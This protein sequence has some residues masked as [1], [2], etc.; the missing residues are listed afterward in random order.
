MVSATFRVSDEGASMFHTAVPCLA[1]RPTFRMNLI[2]G[3][4]LLYGLKSIHKRSVENSQ[5][6]KCTSG[7]TEE[8]AISE[9]RLKVQMVGQTLVLQL[10]HTRSR[11]WCQPMGVSQ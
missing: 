2:F 6:H 10:G 1:T 11:Q 4:D 7:V 3:M 5:A 8:T 9:F